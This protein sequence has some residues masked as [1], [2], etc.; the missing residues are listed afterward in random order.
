MNNH[1]YAIELL[2]N[3][4]N[5]ANTMKVSN[6]YGAKFIEGVNTGLD[7]ISAY[8]DYCIN[9]EELEDRKTTKGGE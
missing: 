6:A 8:I 4:K 9:L 2:K 7:F 1:E 5:R 3:V